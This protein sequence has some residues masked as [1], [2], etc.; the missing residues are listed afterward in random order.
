ME[1]TGA[2]MM[3]KSLEDEGVK[4]VFGLPGGTVIP[5]YD[6]LYDSSLEHVLVRHEQAAA[7]AADGFSRVGDEV[8]V[9]IATSGPGSTNLVT[10]L[11]TAH[12]DSSPMVTITGQV[13]TD[14]IGTDAFQEAHMMGIS[15][16]IVKH[17]MQARRPEDI[18]RMLKDAFFIASTGRPGPVVLDLPVDVQKASA[19]YRR[20]TNPGASYPGYSAAPPEDLTR[21]GEAAELIRH[22]ERPLLIAGNGVNLSR[23]FESLLAFCEKLGIPGATSLLGKGAF[24]GNHPNFIGMV[25]M[26]GSS[27]ANR[28]VMA[29]DL[30]VAVGTRFSDRSTGKSNAFAQSARILHIDIDNSEIGKNI[31]ADVWLLGE[32][33]KILDLLTQEAGKYDTA[34]RRAWIEKIRAMETEEPQERPFSDGE[35]HPRQILKAL[36]EITKGKLIFTTEVGQHQMWAAQYHKAL[37]PRQFVT[38]GGLGTMGFG[39]PASIGAH[40]ARPDLPVVCVAGDGSAMM[41]IQELDTYARYNLPV[42]VLIFDNNCL[43]MVRQWQQLFYDGRY[44]HTLYTR[45]PD[46]VKI[47][48]GMG[49]E[50]FSVE[51]PKEVGSAIERALETPGPVLAHFPIPQMENVFPI[52]PA[53]KPLSHMLLN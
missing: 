35:I 31:S 51:S 13:A 16:S 53:G 26:H 37:Y 41:N 1:L 3:V 14:A 4:T 46:F 49:V 42:K 24:P 29:A 33:G 27:S 28:A 18:P 30:I 12:R 2:Q 39:I 44:A 48:E 32:T 7:H 23:A 10:G 15:L 6:A 5:L 22:A 40:F 9:C 20:P 38:S 11:A 36:D 45:R 50:A 34:S 52:V 43:G 47:A 17:S 8:G 21:L 25:G 19:E